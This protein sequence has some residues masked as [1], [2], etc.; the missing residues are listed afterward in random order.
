MGIH[1]IR[2][3]VLT[4]MHDL[5]IPVADILALSG[6]ATI[7]SLQPYIHSKKAGLNLLDTVNKAEAHKVADN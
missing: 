6:H 4:K 7:Q 2:H 1:R 5:G 3:S